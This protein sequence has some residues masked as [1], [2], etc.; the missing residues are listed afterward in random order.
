MSN[1]AIVIRWGMPLAG[2][3]RMAIEEFAYY[4]QWANQLKK[5]GTIDRFEVYGPRTGNLGAFT[6]FTVVEGKD[7][8]IEE[9][10]D[11]DEFRTRVNRLLLLVKDARVDVCDVAEGMATR[12]KLYAGAVSQLKL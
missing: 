8:A 4:M 1:R 10:A 12:M 7:R 11:S 3:E 5:E 6:G 2:R 9:L